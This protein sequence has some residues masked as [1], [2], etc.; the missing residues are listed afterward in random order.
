[1]GVGEGWVGL[2]W[3]EGGRWRASC[4]SAY[5]SPASPLHLP[6]I[7][8]ISPLYLP[9]ISP[10]GARPREPRRAVGGGLELRLTGTLIPILTLNPNPNPK[11]SQ[12]LLHRCEVEEGVPVRRRIGPG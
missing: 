3:G 9:Y 6:Y 12:R 8:P 10:T 5:I 1:M 7:S 4:S 11:P 2:G